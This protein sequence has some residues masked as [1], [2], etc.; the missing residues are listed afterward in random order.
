[1]TEKT[2][3]THP[4]V[5][6]EKIGDEIILIHLESGVYY[7]LRGTANA[8]WELLMTGISGDGLEE[9]T[10]SHYS[11]DHSEIASQI[12]TFLKV[13]I[14][15]NLVIE[16]DNGNGHRPSAQ[17][18]AFPDK[19]EPPVIEIYKDLQELLLLDPIHEVEQEGWPKKADSK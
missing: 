5:V 7:A 9:I 10:Q 14:D 19:Y 18:L 1:M 15:E 11:D 16:T 17:P 8:L 13:L 2:L 3:K 6:S 12:G 4:Q